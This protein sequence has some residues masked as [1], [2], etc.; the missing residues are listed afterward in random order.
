ML[1]TGP[2]HTKQDLLSIG[3][4]QAHK[5]LNET[6]RVSCSNGLNYSSDISPRP[7]RV[8][9]LQVFDVCRLNYL[10]LRVK[11]SRTSVSL[12]AR[13]ADS[14][15]NFRY[16]PQLEWKSLCIWWCRT[17]RI[18]NDSSGRHQTGQFRLNAHLNKLDGILRAA[19]LVNDV[20]SMASC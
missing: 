1:C 6:R 14:Y 3:F 12:R 8:E 17:L 10:S 5:H 16:V 2:F 18:N 15:G 11:A 7:L 19:G 13:V 4:L 9:V 20:S